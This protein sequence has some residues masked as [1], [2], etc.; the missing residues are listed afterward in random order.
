MNG[1]RA[2]RILMILFGVLAAVS[3]GGLIT[4]AVIGAAAD[5]YGAYGEVPVPGFA[6]VRLPAGETIV[7]FHVGGYGGRGLRVPPL[8]FDITPPP[9]APDP[10]V[11]EDL[12]ATVSVNDD[13][14]RRVW[15]MRVEVE[16]SYRIITRGEVNGFAEPR[17]AFGR[18]RS[19]EGPLWLFAGLSMVTVDLAIAAWWF[20]RR[21]RG[22][23][24]SAPPT[25]AYLP[26]DEGVRLEQLKTIS[27][28]RDSGALTQ[29]EFETE[30]RRILDGR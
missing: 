16:G 23:G 7:S 30:K 11:T 18:T 20:G 2:S 19:V 15:F 4:T 13:A 28:L 12:G 14:H 21:G 6:E 17:L 5:K 24:S 10:S 8:N 9:G 25:G 29:K 3:L 27:A 1:R 22:T 26:T